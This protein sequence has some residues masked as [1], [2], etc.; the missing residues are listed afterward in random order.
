MRN[1]IVT[2]A[3]LLII[4]NFAF[5]QTLKRQDAIWA[6]TAPPNSITVDGKLDEPAWAK[7]ESVVVYYGKSSGIP[8][9]GW[10]DESGVK[11]SDPTRAV[12][13]FLVSGNNLYIGAIVPDS[14]VGGGLFNMFDGFLM[15]MRDHAKSRRDPAGHY[16]P[17]PPF[18]YFYGWVTES[19][20]DPNTGKVGASPGFFGWAGGPRTEGDSLANIWYAVTRVRGVSNTDT[21][22][23]GSFSPD[24][25]YVVELRFNLT[26]R[27]Y[28]VT[29]PQGD[30]IEFNISIYDADWQWPFN[31]DKFSGNRSW[32]QGPWGNASWYNVARIY[33][34]PD[35][36][37]DSPLPDIPP[38]IIIPNGRLHPAPVIDG[39]LSESVW[40]NLN[41]KAIKLAYGD[42]TVIYSYPGVGPYRSGYF[43]PDGAGKGQV[44]DSGKADIKI[45]Y[46]GDTLYIGV[47]IYDQVITSRADYD[48]WD[49]IR[50][51]IEDRG[52]VNPDGALEQRDL[53]LR[54]DSTGKA[55]VDGYLKYLVDSLNAAKVGVKVTGTVNNYNDVDQG[56][57]AEIAIDLTKLGYPAGRGD[58]V[59]FL[60]A[61]LFDYDEFQN[62]N[63]NYGTRTWFFREMPIFSAG[64]AWA[65][66]DPNVDVPVKVPDDITITPTEFK[67]L[68]N[69][70]NPF[71]PATNIMFTMPQRGTV[72]LKVYD[73]VGRRVALLN[74]GEYEAGYHEY[75]FNANNLSSGI[76]FYQLEM[77]DKNGSVVKTNFGKMALIK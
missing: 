3:F 50:I 26:P 58:G 38:D 66:M 33:A 73:I 59:L 17:A 23:N 12:L 65:Y 72:I 70:P 49:G 55:L 8:G 24:T 35:V 63:D 29:R 52:K 19:W 47:K 32:W 67:L 22:A 69:Y 5:G 34:R 16:F 9:S 11:P 36:G 64:P 20:A 40:R 27:G 28:D 53:V 71:N 42:T 62:P 21:A 10:K 13:K 4:V 37:L 56:W 39:D 75:Q 31:Q 6:R 54:L 41:L 61:T 77:K 45:F 14:S 44:L 57:T 43:K 18:E 1:V 76:Y 51:I 74:I 2:L 30:V 25:G 15:N 46:R 68:G 48:K 60:S 7:A